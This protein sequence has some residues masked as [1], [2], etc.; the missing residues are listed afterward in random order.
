M[1]H[2]YIFI[3]AALIA[4]LIM[5]LRR[6]AF[7]KKELGR[8][9]DSERRKSSMCETASLLASCQDMASLREA[10]LEEAKKLTGSQLSAIITPGADGSIKT[11]RSGGLSSSDAEGTL[12][13]ASGILK[14]ALE[15]KMP[16]RAG[17]D[18]LA[19]D[20]S[21]E[22]WS[23]FWVYP[24]KN[25]MIAPALIKDEP[26][27]ALITANKEGGFT[28]Q[29]ESA[30]L[31][32]GYHGALALKKTSFYE[33]VQ[34]LAVKDGLTGLYNYRAF[35][36]KLDLELERARRFNQQLGLLMLDVD[37][38]KLFNDSFGHKAGDE[39]LRAIAQTIAGAIR[40]VDFAARYGGEEFAVILVESS[41]ESALMAAERIRQAVEQ[42][43]LAMGNRSR[44][45]VSIGAASFP[46]D[47]MD[48]ETLIQE[49]DSALY[50][51]KRSGKNI[52]SRAGL[53]TAR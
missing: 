11:F 15:Q 28:D 50:T 39:A 48:K 1:V 34:E 44:L 21:P 8:A 46:D 7:L 2:V 51:S 22:D 16:F 17:T 14:F 9:R 4:S 33:R 40:H 42:N 23:S 27:G 30:L 45:T 35:Q 38:F 49:A 26:V 43:Q 41:P 6:A 18:L 13:G 53:L 12:S 29:D 20:W 10:I 3:A 31:G 5:L 37:N 36:E 19:G 52:V 47:A 25:V 24:V 32:L